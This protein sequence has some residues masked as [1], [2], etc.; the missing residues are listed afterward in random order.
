MAHN[1]FLRMRAIKQIEGG[2]LKA[3][4]LVA[5]EGEAELK[6][7]LGKRQY[8][9]AS[10][11]GQPPA[12]RSGLLKDEVDHEVFPKSITAR[13]GILKGAYSPAFYM[14]FLELGTVNMAPRPSLRPM[15][16]NLVTKIVPRIK[17]QMRQLPKD[18]TRLRDAR[19]R[20]IKG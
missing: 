1:T 4:R 14:R 10:K 3:V 7:L 17:A 12:R 13:I 16:E 15:A 11:P 20:F 9:P 6:R 19:G 18:D 2:L 5:A 8:P